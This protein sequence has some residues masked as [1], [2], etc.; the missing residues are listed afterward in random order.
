MS[1]GASAA[2]YAPLLAALLDQAPRHAFISGV[3]IGAVMR[4]LGY[5]AE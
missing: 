5:E 4:Q 3:P 1:G 2:Q